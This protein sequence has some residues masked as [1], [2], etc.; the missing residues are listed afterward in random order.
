MIRVHLISGSL[1][2]RM[3]NL[4]EYLTKEYAAHFSGWDFSYLSGRV[5]Q[6]EPP[7]NYKAIV[8]N[9]FQGKT[10]LLDMDTGGGEFLC[11]LSNLPPEAYATEGYEPNVPLAEKMLGKKNI[12]LVPIK[13]DGEIPF[14][15]G[16]FDIIINRHGSYDP[17]EIKRALQKNGLFITQQVGGLNGIDINM[18]LGAEFM[19]YSGWGLIKNMEAF[20]NT[21]MEILDFEETIGKMRFNDIGALVYYLKCIPWQVKDFSIDRYYKKLELMNGIIEK[22]GCIYFMLHRFYLIIKNA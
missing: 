11:S 2:K 14:D 4:H 21:G 17:K 5:E 10:R 9:N 12:S 19:D 15:D 3:K 18:A 16:Y 13:K 22:K 20:E 8:E 7:W 6:D 1:G